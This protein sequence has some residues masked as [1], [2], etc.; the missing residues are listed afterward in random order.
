MQPR[1]ADLRPLPDGAVCALEASFNGHRGNI[2]A[3]RADDKFLVTTGDF[4]PATLRGHVSS[5]GVGGYSHVATSTTTTTTAVQKV[6]RERTY[7]R[8]HV[9]PY[10]QS[11][12]SLPRR[13]FPGLREDNHVQTM[14]FNLHTTNSISAETN[15]MRVL[16]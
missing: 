4:E 2:F 6:A 3:A 11:A 1:N 9:T 16:T 8:C 14:H 7:S 15:R 5:C 10:R 13:C 12:A